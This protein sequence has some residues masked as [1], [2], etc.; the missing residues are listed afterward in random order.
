MAQFPP[1]KGPACEAGRCTCQPA[2]AAQAA[3]VDAFLDKMREER[4]PK[5]DPNP[6]LAKLETLPVKLAG[7]TWICTA[8]R[9]VRPGPGTHCG[10]S[11]LLV[12]SGDLETDTGGFV[13]RAT[14]APVASL[15]RKAPPGSLAA[16]KA[17]GT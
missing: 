11:I 5:L 10:F 12:E 8:C 14:C 4:T 2:C 16:W 3:R 13:V 15:Y 1:S 7:R 17:H 9:T 6:N